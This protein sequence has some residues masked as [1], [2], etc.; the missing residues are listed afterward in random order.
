MKKKAFLEIGKI[1]TTHGVKGFLKIESWCDDV[2]IFKSL[3]YIYLDEKG[4][5]RFKIKEVKFIKNFAL[6]LLKEIESIEKA[7]KFI[8]EIVYVK[9]E[10]L[11]IDE[12]KYFIQDLVGAEIFDYYEKTKCY[13]KILDVIKIKNNSLYLIRDEKNKEIM[14]P[15]N[16]EIVKEINLEEGKIYVKLIEGLLEI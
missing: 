12:K 6:L 13:G 15:I 11:K 16:N 4:E 5:K 7:E 14:I 3:N 9:R 8:G 1:I 2:Y 10:D